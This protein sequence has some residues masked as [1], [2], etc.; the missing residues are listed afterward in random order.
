MKIHTEHFYALVAW[1]AAL[2]FLGVAWFGIAWIIA[3]AY[4]WN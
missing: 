3:N 1:A 2:L 4:G